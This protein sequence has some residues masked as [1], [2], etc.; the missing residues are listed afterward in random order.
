VPLQSANSPLPAVPVRFYSYFMDTATTN[1]YDFGQMALEAAGVA[2]QF[3]ICGDTGGVGNFN[4]VL[5]L[6][7]CA[8]AGSLPETRARLPSMPAQA[9]SSR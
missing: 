6:N 1:R 8:L 4:W 9:V 7:G 5:Y 2:G 3:R